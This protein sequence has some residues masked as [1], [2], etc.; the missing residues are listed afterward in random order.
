MTWPRE[1]VR[2]SRPLPIIW[3]LWSLLG[4]LLLIGAAGCHKDSRTPAESKPVPEVAL[5]SPQRTSLHWTVQQ[6]GWIEAYEET[7]IIP[8]IAGYV[9]KWNVDIG[10]LVTKGQVL[11]VLRV[12]DMVAELDKRT[13]EVEQAR[14]LFDVAV[15][16]LVSVSAQVEEA[17]AGVSRTQAQQRF[18]QMQHQRVGQ[19]LAESVINKRVEEETWNELRSAEAGVKEAEAKLARAEADRKE[20]EAVRDKCR[21]DIAVAEAARAEIQALIDYATLTA[22]FDGIVSRRNINT[23]DF[24]QPPSASRQDAV[25]VVQRRDVMRVFVE[26]PESDAVWVKDGTPA[27]IRVPILKGLELHGTVK[28]MSYALKRQS[29]T[30][31]A[32]ID[33]PNPEDLLRPGMFASAAIQVERADVLTLPAAAIATEGNVN[34]GYHEYCFVVENG[35]ARR[36]P[37]EVVVRGDD[38]VQVL[39]KEV[40]GTWEELTGH[41]T[42]VMGELSTLADGQEVRIT[43]DLAARTLKDAS[44]TRGSY[45]RAGGG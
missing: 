9:A 18:R 10:D 11:A 40:H 31:L 39:K 32:E 24:V 14:K 35:K 3:C 36:M 29:R 13:A 16:H 43:G 21:V 25:Y 7:S 44:R 42:V 15:A 34:E 1:C 20:S 19:L 26:V 6:P 2:S 33:L 4:S 23:G 45:R 41:E 37:M 22:P 38:R 27:R 8:K 28:R 17:R 30:L 5:V 12:P